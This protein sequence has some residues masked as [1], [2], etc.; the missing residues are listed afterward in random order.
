MYH[1]LDLGKNLHSFHCVKSLCLIENYI[2]LQT[3][4][5]VYEVFEYL[6]VKIECKCD[7]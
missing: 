2:G 3:H 7:N 4:G 1:G 5:N 6:N